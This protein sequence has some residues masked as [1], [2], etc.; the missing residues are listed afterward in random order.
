MNL[1]LFSLQMLLAITVN[2]LFFCLSWTMFLYIRAS[3]LWWRPIKIFEGVH[4]FSI[5]TFTASQ[6]WQKFCCWSLDVAASYINWKNGTACPPICFD[7]RRKGVIFSFFTTIRLYMSVIYLLLHFS[8]LC[9]SQ[10]IWKDFWSHL[11]SM[12]AVFMVTRVVEPFR[13]ILQ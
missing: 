5:S 13:K 8:S 10:S 6:C 7:L 9:L 11:E 12:F 3:V 4:F 1:E 2:V